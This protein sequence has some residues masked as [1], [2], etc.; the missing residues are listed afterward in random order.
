MRHRPLAPIDR[1]LLASLVEL[2]PQATA[3][4]LARRYAE[5][6]GRQRPHRVTIQRALSALRLSWSRRT[7]DLRDRVEDLE[8]VLASMRADLERE[9]Q[10]VADAERRADDAREAAEHAIQAERKRLAALKR[11]LD[12]KKSKTAAHVALKLLGRVA[13]VLQTPADVVDTLLDGELHGPLTSM[14]LSKRQLGVYRRA[15]M[16]AETEIVSYYS[17]SVPDELRA[18]WEEEA[19]AVGLT[20]QDRVAYVQRVMAD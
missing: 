17:E 15:V 20:G 2:H 18:K 16:E 3:D 11:D 12:S 13:H 10:R 14:T 5:R 7:Q 19:D 6:T 8:D 9:R 1:D 4:E